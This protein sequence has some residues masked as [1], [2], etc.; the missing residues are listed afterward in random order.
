M[1][2]KKEKTGFLKKIS[3]DLKTV[4]QRDPATKNVWEA[5][6][7]SSGFQAVCFYRFYHLLWCYGLHFFARFFS[8]MNHWLTGVDI[9]PAA[10]IGRRFFIDHGTGIVVGETSEIG[11]DVTLYQGATLGGVSREPIKRHPTLEDKVVVCAGAKILGPIRIGRGSHIGACSVVVEDVPPE[12]TVVGIPG[13]VIHRSLTLSNYDL[14][15]NHL[16]DPEMELIYQLEERLE[17]LE[18]K[19]AKG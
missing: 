6:L 11:E 9:H 2:E 10:K 14:A 18:K 1:I 8:R 4:Y 3:E 13:K 5:F 19:L 16:P 12:S 15:H 7:C 17:I